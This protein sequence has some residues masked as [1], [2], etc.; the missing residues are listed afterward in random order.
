VPK[1]FALLPDDSK[2]DFRE[3]AAGRALLSIGRSSFQLAIEILR[4][5]SPNSLRREYEE[6]RAWRLLSCLPPGELPLLTTAADD[7]SMELRVRVARLLPSFHAFPEVVAT[8]LRLLKD[9]DP[10]V[11]LAAVESLSYVK[12]PS[13]QFL[14]SLRGILEDSLESERLR[15]AAGS[16]IPY[17][18]PAIAVPALIKELVSPD[19]L[20]R[21]FAAH[22]L[23]K[24]E[25][26]SLDAVPLLEELLRDPHED[27]R[28]AALSALERIGATLACLEPAIALVEADKE[29][30]TATGVICQLG[31]TAA[32]AVPAL[33]RELERAQADPAEEANVWMWRRYLVTHA[34]GRIGPAAKAAVPLLHRELEDHSSDAAAR[35]LGSIGPAALEGGVRASAMCVDPEFEG[36]GRLT[37]RRQCITERPVHLLVSDP[38]RSR[39]SGCRGTNRGSSARCSMPERRALSCRW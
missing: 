4:R 5:D 17:L 27:V 19:P 12:E 3:D 6:R 13:D 28:I 24:L 35:A 1:L 36:R 22:A 34:L 11:R 20:V 18:R 39:S 31:A 37:T 30:D 7:P 33:I 9:R 23:G 10:E 14:L 26:K 21:R 29:L 15:E 8:H 2:A 32:P 16:L 38:N 25:K